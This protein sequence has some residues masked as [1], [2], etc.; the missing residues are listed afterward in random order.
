MCL[1]EFTGNSVT[2]ITAI[3]TIEADKAQDGVIYNL[4]GQKVDKSYKGL[5]I[6]NGKKVINK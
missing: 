1:Y 4:A 5:V 6:K 3:N 2:I